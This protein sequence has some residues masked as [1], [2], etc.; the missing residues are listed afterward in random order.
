MN[1]GTD[2]DSKGKEYQY[3]CN[4]QI[5]GKPLRKDNWWKHYGNDQK[6]AIQADNT[7]LYNITA[8]IWKQPTQK[9]YTPN[10]GRVQSNVFNLHHDGPIKIREV[11]R[12]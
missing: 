3:P 11:R 4:S 6:H 12:K 7:I 9:K 5:N 1:Q 8:F 10:H 2:N